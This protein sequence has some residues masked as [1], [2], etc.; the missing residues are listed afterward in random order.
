MIELTTPTRLIQCVTAERNKLIDKIDLSRSYNGPDPN[1]TE[2]VEM[3]AR[4][5]A[6]NDVLKWIEEIEANAA[7]ARVREQIEAIR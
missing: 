1:P 6:M 4:L 5:R 3:N 7:I 2:T